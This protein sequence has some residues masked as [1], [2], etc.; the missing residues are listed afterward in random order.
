MDLTFCG[1]AACLHHTCCLHSLLYD[2]DRNRYSTLLQNF[3]RSIR[4]YMSEENAVYSQNCEYL[5]SS[6]EN[7]SLKINESKRK[8]KMAEG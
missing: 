6:A 8:L 2:Q 7:Y 4:R 3:Y 1:C 5:E